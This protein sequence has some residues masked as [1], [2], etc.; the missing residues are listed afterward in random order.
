MPP[1]YPGILSRLHR[2]FQV[3]EGW[4][5]SGPYRTAGWGLIALLVAVYPANIHTLVNEVYLLICHVPKR[6]AYSAAAIRYYQYVVLTFRLVRTSNPSEVSP[7]NPHVHGGLRRE[8]GCL[9]PFLRP[10][11]RP[12]LF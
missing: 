8:L 5:P 3:L 11:Q 6:F 1:Y 4:F 7:K 12:T 2:F 10:H 9:L